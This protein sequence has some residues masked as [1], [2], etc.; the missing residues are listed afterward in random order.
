MQ[1]EVIKITQLLSRGNNQYQILVY[2]NDALDEQIEAKE[3]PGGFVIDKLILLEKGSNS[4][5]RMVTDTSNNELRF[6]KLV[7]PDQQSGIHV[8]E[9]FARLTEREEEIIKLISERS[10][11]GGRSVAFKSL[12]NYKATGWVRIYY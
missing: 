7:F 4:V 8:R 11:L 9:T 5:L 2:K 3:A 10:I 1:A 12:S 6:L